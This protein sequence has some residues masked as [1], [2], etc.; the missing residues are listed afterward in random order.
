MS[1]QLTNCSGN[2]DPYIG[3]LVTCSFT[4]KFSACYLKVTLNKTESTG[5]YKHSFRHALLPQ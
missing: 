4:M 3:S 5:Y 2:S 1:Q